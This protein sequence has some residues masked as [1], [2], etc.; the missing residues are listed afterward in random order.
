MSKN[1][2]MK[3]E[4]VRLVSDWKIMKEEVKRRGGGFEFS[5]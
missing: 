2:K 5:K 1:Y 3:M 4:N